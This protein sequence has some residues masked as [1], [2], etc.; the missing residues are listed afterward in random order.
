MTYV[1]VGHFYCGELWTKQVLPVSHT[2]AKKGLSC[3]NTLNNFA[4]VP[5]NLIR[6]ESE[7]CNASFN[8]AVLEKHSLSSS[9]LCIRCVDKTRKSREIAVKV[10]L[11][12]PFPASLSPDLPC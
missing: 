9:F 12:N 2:A 8:D 10:N 3:L 6:S 11:W 7:L 1:V 4:F 5:G